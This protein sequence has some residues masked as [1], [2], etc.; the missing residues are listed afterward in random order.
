MFSEEHRRATACN[1]LRKNH[2]RKKKVYFHEIFPFDTCLLIIHNRIKCISLPTIITTSTNLVTIDQCCLFKQFKDVY[3]SDTAVLH[4]II[5]K[6][7]H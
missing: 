4:T 3:G 5:T 7:G 2:N 6:S 1:G